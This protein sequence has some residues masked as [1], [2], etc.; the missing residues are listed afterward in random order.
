MI[1]YAIKTKK[2]L[3]V[4]I[5]TN[6]RLL[7]FILIGNAPITNTATFDSKAIAKRELKRW[8]QRHKEYKKLKVVKIEIREIS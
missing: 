1:M 4:G 3:Y 7:S 2:D 6:N 8:Q 5:K